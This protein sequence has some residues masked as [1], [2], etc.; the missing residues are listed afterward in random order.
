MNPKLI[1]TI[2]FALS[3]FF[4]KAQTLQKVPLQDGLLPDTSSQK[5]TL[6]SG[7]PSRLND[8]DMLWIIDGKKF[9]YADVPKLYFNLSNISG[10]RVIGYQNDSIKVYGKNAKDGVIIMTTKERID[11]ISLKN[12]VRKY[13][14]DSSVSANKI[15]VKINGSQRLSRPSQP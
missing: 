5:V 1:I 14:K 6:H 12:I 8:P 2:F 15:A 13:A 7:C 9:K 11:W 4:L 3:I 10:G